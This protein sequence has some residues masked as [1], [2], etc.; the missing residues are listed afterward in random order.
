MHI[1]HS[2]I[3]HFKMSLFKNKVFKV[4]EMNRAFI[5]GKNKALWIKDRM[6]NFLFQK[7]GK[8]WSIFLKSISSTRTLSFF[9]KSDVQFMV[10]KIVSKFI[11]AL[12]CIKTLE[13]W[14]F[15]KFTFQQ[16]EYDE[17]IPK[18]LLYYMISMLWTKNAIIQQNASHPDY[19]SKKSHFTIAD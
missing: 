11:W 12:Y 19:M 6:W 8:V 17:W 18:F 4:D 13:F 7:Y 14:T 1:V 16:S 15:L 10:F 3:I 5:I 2:S 9:L